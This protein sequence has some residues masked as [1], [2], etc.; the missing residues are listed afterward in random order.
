MATDSHPDDDKLRETAV[1]GEADALLSRFPNAA[2]SAD[3]QRRL[4]AAL[5]LPL[6][7]LDGDQRTR[8]VKL[9]MILLLNEGSDAD[10]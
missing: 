10:A 7:G 3:E 9:I 2:A 5:Y 8:V 6:L 1:A 4:R